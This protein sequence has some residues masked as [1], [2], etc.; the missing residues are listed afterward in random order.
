MMAL[1]DNG[2]LVA[3]RLL[4]GFLVKYILNFFPC[5]PNE[6]F[7]QWSSIFIS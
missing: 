6:H 2:G 7:Y 4:I 1:Y 5:S 3:P